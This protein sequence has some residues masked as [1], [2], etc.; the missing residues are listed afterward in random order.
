MPVWRVTSV[1][2]ERSLETEIGA[3][4][5]ELLFKKNHREEVNG[6]QNQIANS[7]L[8]MELDGPKSQDL[9]RSWWTPRPSIKSWLR[10]TKRN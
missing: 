4:K 5:E 7:G 1:V 3:L 2:S 6:L 9:R 10:R 8:T